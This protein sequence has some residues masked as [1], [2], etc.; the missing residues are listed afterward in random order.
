MG[1]RA[2]SS[3]VLAAVVLILATGCVS[4]SGR[5]LGRWASDHAL[6]AEVKMRLAPLRGPSTWI[7]ADTYDSTVYLSGVVDS[8]ATKQRA[9]KLARGVEGVDEVVLSLL[10][11]HA[12]GSSASIRTDARR[13]VWT[14]TAGHPHPLLALL[15]GL[16]RIESDGTMRGPMTAFD[17]AG[18]RVA[19]IY[20]VSMRDLSQNGV[21]NLRGDGLAIDHVDIYPFSSVPD[22]PEP[23]YHVVLWHLSRAQARALK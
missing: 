2:R 13:E 22:I 15:P 20:V 14:R 11:K 21:D 19:T 12:G 6:T 23:T 17:Q 8:E 16:V 7:R 4:S 5:S 9:E 3:A 1:G 18:H 10:V